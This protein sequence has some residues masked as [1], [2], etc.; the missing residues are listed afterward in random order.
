MENEQLMLRQ[1]QR[2]YQAQL[3]LERDSTVFAHV[4]SLATALNG[5]IKFCVNFKGIDLYFTYVFLHTL[6]LCSADFVQ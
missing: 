2:A 1:F 5:I 3:Q 4:L 6:V